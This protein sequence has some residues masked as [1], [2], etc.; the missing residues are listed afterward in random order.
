M[1]AVNIHFA[2]ADAEFLGIQHQHLPFMGRYECHGSGKTG[3][4]IGIRPA[5]IIERERG[6][7]RH[8]M[9]VPIHR[10]AWHRM[11]KPWQS[12]RLGGMPK[13]KM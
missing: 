8:G 3:G 13:P 7:H 11:H 1:A 2:P 6:I 4:N 9:P 10:S 5:V 12:L